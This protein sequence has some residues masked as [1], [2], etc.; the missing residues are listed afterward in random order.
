M[1]SS[2]N[3][4]GGGHYMIEQ[5]GE[6]GGI[7]RWQMHSPTKTWAL[8]N[9][10]KFSQDPLMEGKVS[11]GKG[12]DSGCLSKEKREWTGLGGREG[13]ELAPN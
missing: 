4:P 10:K 7:R 8:K 2:F 3:E 12:W 9:S 5:G 11:A 1:N 6:E 13:S